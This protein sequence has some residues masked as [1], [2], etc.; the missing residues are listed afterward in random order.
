MNLD[1]FNQLCLA[2]AVSLVFVSQSAWS[3]HFQHAPEVTSAHIE[4][5]KPLLQHL[6][7]VSKREEF[8]TEDDELAEDE[9]HD[10]D[11]ELND[12]DEDGESNEEDNDGEPSPP[13]DHQ[14]HCMMTP[15]FAQMDL[16][17]HTAVQSG[18]WSQGETWGG[19][20]PE[21][22]AIVHIPQDTEVT[23]ASQVNTRLKTVRI[24]GKLAFSHQHNTELNVD[25]LFSSCSGQL[26]IGTEETPVDDEVNTKIVFIDDGAISD[27]KLLGRGAVLMGQTR[28][29]GSPKTHRAV[30]QPQAERG[31]SALR[32][33]SVP[34]GWKVDDQLIITGTTPNDPMSDEI[35][36]ITQIIENR[37]S[38]DRPLTL[39][40]TAPRPDLNVY[41][42][43][44]TR[45]IEFVSEN[46]Q[47]SRRGHVMFMHNQDV[48]V[49]YARFTELGRTDKTRPLNDFEF[50]FHDGGVGD[51]APDKADVIALGGENV[52]GRYAVHFHRTGTD[53]NSEPARVKG[54]V[55]FN[56]PGWGY[57]SHSSHVDMIDNVSYGLQGAG[58]YTEAGDEIGSMQ[59]NIA[60]RSVN[61]SFTLD[62]QGAIDP[63]LNANLMDYGHDGD[64]FWLTGNRVS[65]IDNVAS[66]ASAHGIIYWTDGILE[67]DSNLAT[68]MSI[69]VK[70]LANGHLIPDRETVPVWWAPLAESR[71]NQSYGAT[72]GFRIRYVHAKNYLG[73]EE[74]SD[75]HRSPPQAYIDTLTPSVNDLTV[76]G[77]RD[78]VLLNYNER[79]SLDGARIYGFGKDISKFSFNPGTAKSGVGLDVSNDA[80]HGP[81]TI[82][83]VTIEGFGMG[84]AAP[85][86]GHWQIQNMLLQNNHTDMLTLETETSDTQVTLQNVMFATFADEQGRISQLPSHISIND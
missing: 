70:E 73:R 77:N 9:E 10:E 85:V 65:M 44:A 74:Q 2:G 1:Q 80:T 53:L 40:H 51:D 20:P 16:M 19:V 22:G 83:N 81:A 59:G 33:A 49:Q 5:N 75:F 45:N 3:E 46:P 21:A 60:I 34:T 64:G 18:N 55:V 54:A 36:T 42:A 41:V 14:H 27:S 50:Q 28:I 79:L 29:Y 86:N 63:D 6:E 17:T 12:D 13:G 11:D 35:R 39:D 23:I 62:D 47:V 56:G 30:I 82:N 25:T 66:G 71:D 61:S 43:N 38:L 8:D 84:F 68:R 52:R 57:V 58:F 76:W 24:D 26:H 15:E 32:L 48:V 67:P 31:D 69:P 78:G 7:S 4:N 72:V 37:V